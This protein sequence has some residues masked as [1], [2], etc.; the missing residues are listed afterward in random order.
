MLM[1]R[2]AVMMVKGR[3]M[4][5]GNEWDEMF[6]ILCCNHTVLQS[7]LKLTVLIS[8]MLKSYFLN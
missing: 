4:S 6:V 1:R 7:V 3:C 2:R 8:S 5:K